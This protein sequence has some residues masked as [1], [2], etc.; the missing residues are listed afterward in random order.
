MMPLEAL[1]SE[2]V[3]EIVELA[4]R[5]FGTV[6]IDLPSNWTNWSLSLLAQSDVV[7]LVSELS[8][9]SLHRARRQLELIKSQDLGTL[10]LRVVINRFEKGRSL[11]RPGDVR[12]ALGR[13]ISYTIANDHPL[14]STAVDQGLAIADIR[15]KSSIGKDIDTLDA[16]VA[17]ALGLGR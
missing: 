2:Q 17:A 10:E 1:S 13:D 11:V 5:E 3:I 16:G 4:K 9:A 14:M 15:R 12:E 6:F 8:V 7:L